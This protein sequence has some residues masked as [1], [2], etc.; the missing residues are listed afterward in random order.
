MLG[1]EQLAWI[2]NE[3]VRSD[4]T[5]KIVASSVPLVAPTTGVSAALLGRD[6]WANGSGPEILARTGF[7]RELLDL[8]HHLDAQ[9]VKNLVFVGADIHQPLATRLTVDLDGDGV[10]LAF[11]E[12][13]VGPFSAGLR[14]G[15]IE[16]DPTL[17][18]EILFTES[19]HFNFGHIQVDRAPAGRPRLIFENRGEDGA[20]RPGSRVE[21]LGSG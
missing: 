3:L 20:V 9:R 18:P 14:L 7:E 8:L 5:W 1:P 16:L 19:G 15:P 12:F 2:K 4:A 6:G 13:I 21:L 11:H 10:P 17:S